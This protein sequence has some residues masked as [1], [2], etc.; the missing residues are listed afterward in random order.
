MSNDAKTVYGG[1]ADDADMRTNATPPEQLA[2]E[3]DEWGLS[4]DGLTI[5][6]NPSNEI[7]YV[8]LMRS[9]YADYQEN[10]AAWPTKAEAQAIMRGVITDH[11]LAALV[12]GLVEALRAVEL[13]LDRNRHELTRAGFNYTEK[14]WAGRE[15]TYAPLVRTALATARKAGVE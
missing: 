2:P 10:D 1:F 6:R 12:P 5:F 8:P 3:G 7:G 13:S 11:R 4:V 9:S 15:P 14:Q